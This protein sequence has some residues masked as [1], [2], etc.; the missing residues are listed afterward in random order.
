MWSQN[1]ICSWFDANQSYFIKSISL[2]LWSHF[3]SNR[4][5]R[6]RC[7]SLSC[8]TEYW[9]TIQEIGSFSKK[10]M[11]KCR[12]WWA[13][14]TLCA[15]WTPVRRWATPPPS[16]LTRQ[17][18]SPQTGKKSKE[19]DSLTAKTGENVLNLKSEE[20]GS[21]TNRW[22]LKTNLTFSPNRMTVVQAYIC[23]KHYQVKLLLLGLLVLW[24]AAQLLSVGMFGCRAWR[25]DWFILLFWLST[26]TVPIPI[27]IF[28]SAWEGGP[29]QDPRP[30]GQREGARHS[31]HL[32]QL[33]LRLRR[34]GMSL[35]MQPTNTKKLSSK[36][37]PGLN[38]G[39]FG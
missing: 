19:T 30:G 39:A 10:L 38:L 37:W 23:A 16:A 17:A 33:V 22:T 27:F 11:Q 25:V 34:T 31:G 15:T 5:V 2:S 24:S 20:T 7:I 32:R 14:T 3:I 21:L 28:V 6:V 29:A 13:T 8:T 9:S 26:A 35:L 12:K 36:Y 4:V 18:L 1:L